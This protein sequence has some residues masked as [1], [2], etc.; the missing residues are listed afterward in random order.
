MS[1]TI[2]SEITKY[3]NF[4]YLE[5]KIAQNNPALLDKLYNILPC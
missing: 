3:A 1:L 5:A 4:E 2:K